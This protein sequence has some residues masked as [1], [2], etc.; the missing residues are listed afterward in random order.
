MNPRLD[1]QS[2]LIETSL[3]GLRTVIQDRLRSGEKTVPQHDVQTCDASHLTYLYLIYDQ[4]DQDAIQPWQ[5]FFFQQ[6]LE[7]L[8]PYFEGTET[9]IR[10]SHEENLRNCDAVLIHYGAAGE[11][12]LRRKLREVQK[13][14][15][16]APTR[17]IRIT[18]I[19]LAP[20][21]N[22]QKQ[23]FQTHEA[24]M[25][26]Q[27]EGFSADAFLPFLREAKAQLQAGA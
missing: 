12:W 4:K 11:S 26:P 15:G 25:I 3:E 19:S 23:S 6:G 7:V 16:Y 2:D 9:E 10:E 14:A 21:K 13:S 24:M 8:H 1:A 17:P 27:W 20:P 18:G 5:Q 22:S